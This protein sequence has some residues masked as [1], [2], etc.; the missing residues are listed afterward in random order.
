MQIDAIAE[1]Q[2]AFRVLF[3]NWVLAIP[4]AV[5]AVVAGILA[6]VLLAGIMAVLTT[7]G[8]VAGSDPSAVLNAL[9]AGA[10]SLLLFFVVVCLLS[11]LAVAVV[12]GGAE[13]V[14]H[15]E[16]ADLSHG[17]G[18]AAGKL[19]QLIGLFVVEI[20]LVAICGALTIILI[21]PLLGLVLVFFFMYTIPAIVVGNE[22]VFA[23]LGT[24][25]RLV[26]QNLGPSILAFIG[27]VVIQ[28]IGAIINGLFSHAAILSLLVNLVVGGLTAAYSALVLVRF[29]DLLRGAGAPAITGTR[30]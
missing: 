18:K 28:V 1:L 29:Y 3:K 21:G 8:L 22:G 30:P 17:L 11:L 25:W 15:G 26:R 12:M 10:P 19:P 23:A 7:G 13:R 5:V 14:W 27:I 20:I 16:P 2:N 24:S 4:T 9:R 6:L